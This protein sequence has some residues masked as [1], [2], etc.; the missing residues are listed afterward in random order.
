MFVGCKLTQIANVYLDDFRQAR[1]A[2]Y[3]KVKD[4]SKK[5]GKDC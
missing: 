5:F 1:A 2:D 4:L 3:S